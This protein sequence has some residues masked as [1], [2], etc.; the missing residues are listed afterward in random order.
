MQL[1]LEVPKPFICHS[2]EYTFI[3]SEQRVVGSNMKHNV[4]VS[5]A[6]SVAVSVVCLCCLSLSLSLSESL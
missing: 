1:S 3:V 4:S 2:A 5:V 6:V